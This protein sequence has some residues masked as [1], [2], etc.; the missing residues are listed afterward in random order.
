MI[1][2]STHALIP[3]TRHARNLAA[4]MLI[5]G[6]G[7]VGADVPERV[8][9]PE[10]ETPRPLLRYERP[11]YRNFALNYYTNP[12]DHSLP[13]RDR[14]NAIYNSFGDYLLTGYPLYDW[15][16]RRQPGQIFGSGITKD[17]G[18]FENVID[19]LVVAR[20]GY[21]DWGYSAMVGDAMIAR[22]SPLILSRTDFNGARFDLANRYLR[23]SFLGSRIEKPT[24]TR[25]S[26][27]SNFYNDSTTFREGRLFTYFADGSVLLLGSRLE[28]NLGM[29]RLGLNG[30]NIHLYQSTRS[31]GS[32]LKGAVHPKQP[33]LDWAIV[34]FS[35][36]SPKDGRGGP[37]IHDVQLIID[38]E[39]RP[40]IIPG[41]IRRRAGLDTQVGSISQ[42][43]G[44]FRPIVYDNPRAGRG[45]GSRASA[46]FYRGRNEIP[47]YADY[48][49]RLD[50]EAGIDVSDI[51][52]LKGLLANLEVLPPDAIHQVDG[53]E[54]LVYLFDLSAEST[55]RA[56]EVQAMVAND[57]RIDVATLSEPDPAAPNRT[58]QF[59][60]TFYRT[61]KRAK[62]NVRDLSNLG[63]VRFGVGE[64]TGLFTYSGDFNLQF[65][66]AEFS[67]EF[68]RS[69]LFS[70]FPARQGREAI[71][72]KA[73]SFSD[74]GSAYYIN[75]TR[76]FG[77]WQFGGELFA[78]NPDYQTTLRTYQ[79]DTFVC[80][81]AG[82]FG[83]MVNE[84]LYWD[85]IQDNEDGDAY[86]DRR[87]GELLAL[88]R[89]P[90]GD[91][92]NDVLIGLDE[93]QD[94]L[95][96]INRN[97]NQLPDYVEPFLL[98]HVESNEYLYGL[99]RNNNDEPDVR[100]DDL[101]W[102]YPYDFDQKGHNLFAHM[103]LADHWSVTLGRYEVR[104]VAGPGRNISTYGIL[105]YRRE[106]ISQRQK[107]FV[108]NHFR[109]VRDDIAD[110]YTVIDERPELRL[111][112][113]ELVFRSRQVRADPLLYLDSYVNE[114]YFD[115]RVTAWSN[116]HLVQ[117]L[118]LR[119]NWQQR[120]QLR[121][122]LA[123]RERRLDFL[124]NVSKAE[125][126]W[127]IGSWTLTPQLK[128]LVLRLIDREA[129]RTLRSERSVIPILKGTY[130]LSSRTTL[131][132][133]LEGWGPLP[134][135]FE[136]QGRNSDS[137]E[138]R[139]SFITFTNRT[140]YFGYDLYTIIGFN[141]DKQR[142][143]SPFQRDRSS[144]VWRFFVRGLIG[145]TEYGD[146]I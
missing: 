94:G 100:E 71:Y 106:N 64:Q 35:D 3:G 102:D 62:G 146:L 1:H 131:R 42:R 135:S 145:F 47:L 55:V 29:L 49:Y 28:T 88:P 125:Y 82:K 119:I 30:A 83:G 21:G 40:D 25:S 48:M 68:A 80:C 124:T 50:H 101:D 108:E 137:F 109:R 57:Y 133:G 95:P 129:D 115:A 123:Q 127:G 51:T 143:D 139:T 16:E 89:D 67:G 36:D 141:K 4:V 136:E 60:S 37:V 6:A 97:F 111:T 112:D 45:G 59:K 32:T 128:F 65:A 63:Q 138:R 34:R 92:R 19:N 11:G 73:P 41:V 10:I 142:F 130:P 24:D 22:L 69:A 61:V 144:D 91:D 103:S 86:P 78:I 8:S 90:Y 126:A 33:L 23:F 53:D 134:Y 20:D 117:K 87:P 79:E 70:R 113:E 105:N 2:P 12:P 17:L 31:G 58:R 118:R 18:T 26:D 43:T 122:G 5:L 114:S 66:G 140:A 74:R 110:E 14:Q 72:S 81:Y 120:G 54:Q 13:Y 121:R 52:N 27:G 85:L 77:R 98:F 9:I 132:F 116:L 7:G 56:V 104:Q 93:D 44:V 99:D 107:L 38:G 75:G 46:I 39:P 96:D 84:T 76:W 15:T